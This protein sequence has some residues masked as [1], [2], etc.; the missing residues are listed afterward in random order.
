MLAYC[1]ADPCSIPNFFLTPFMMAMGTVPF[2]WLSSLG[3]VSC[4]S[5]FTDIQERE[6]HSFENLK[7]HSYLKQSTFWGLRCH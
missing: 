2:H 6:E 4:L 7:I 1:A 5:S 3:F